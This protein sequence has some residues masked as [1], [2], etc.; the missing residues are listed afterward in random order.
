MYELRH[1][2]VDTICK[3]RQDNLPDPG[4]MKLPTQQAHASPGGMA[5]VMARSEKS[6]RDTDI[7][8][9]GIR[10]Y[11]IVS[12]RSPDPPRCGYV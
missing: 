5:G 7:A 2:L 11:I 9:R 1:A 4:R 12:D 6:S 8:V 3:T 10:R